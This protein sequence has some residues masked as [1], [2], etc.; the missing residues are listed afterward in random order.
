[1]S[2]KKETVSLKKALTPIHLWTIGVG[3]V[4]SGNYFGWN[5]GLLESGY[6]GMIIATVIMAI[7]YLT[8]TLGISELSTALPY[9]GGP[10]SFARRAMGKYFGFITGVG[11]VLQYVIAAPIIAIGIGGYISFLFPAVSTVAAAAIMYI[12]FMIIHI[13][14]IK[15]YATLEMILVFIALGLLA[16]MYFVGLPQIQMENLFSSDSALIPG[17]FAGVWSALPYAMWLFLAI[18]MLP[19][20]S[21]E[22]RDVQRD[23][24][25]GL[26]SGMITLLILSVLTTTVAIGLAGIDVLATAEDP[27]PAALAAA[28]GDTYWLAQILASIG[29]VGLIAS[30]SGVI[31]AYSRQVYALS[32]AGYLPSFLSLMHKKRQTPYMAI[33][34]PGFIGLALVILFNPDDL[35]LVSTFG[36]LISYITMN[37]SV[38][39]LRKKEPNLN[40]TFRTPFYPFTPII[41]LTLAIIAIFASFFANITFFFVCIIVFA[42]A[43]LYYYLW[44]RHHINEDAPEE[45]FSKEQ[46]SSTITPND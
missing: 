42:L 4:I 27:L 10:Y 29:L 33:I 37:L 39:I 12:F 26:I 28:F 44:A 2:S 22:T 38:L 24:P 1:M 6:L 31:L 45:R 13:V 20:L 9:A 32:R 15:E 14:G 30:F 21:E 8:M 7:M 23:M 25:K 18:E 3:I 11:V 43:S 36:A 34:L 19:M 17:G 46:N 40:R 35:I 16:L 41:S 5:F